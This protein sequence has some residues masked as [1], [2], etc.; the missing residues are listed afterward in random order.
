MI[1]SCGGGKKMQRYRI[2]EV[3]KMVDVPVETIRFLEQKGLVSPEKNTETGYRFYSVW[4]INLIL[5]YKKFRKIGFSSRETVD[6]VRDSS[7]ADL[8]EQL[9]AKRKEAA[10]LSHFY[11]A[12]TL[13]LKNF[14]SVL[15]NAPELVV[16]YY[17]MN[18]PENY[19]LF[20]RAHSGGNLKMTNARDTE[21]GFEEVTRN[22]PFVEHIYRLKKGELMLP[23]DQEEAEWG[24]T[25][26]KYWA[27][28][29]GIQLLPRMEHI[30]PVTAL[31]T[32]ITLD[33]KEYFTRSAAENALQYMED[34]HY[35]LCGDILGVYIA[36]V[37][38][39][40]RNVRYMELWMP[41]RGTDIPID[42]SEDQQR[43][44]LKKIFG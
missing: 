26:K 38:E 5:D 7:F 12:K 18:R 2:G 33:E 22:Y 20:T 31:F 4:D 39:G 36:T 13:K 43:R 35:T 23:E 42:F 44:E 24:F 19:S 37:R 11:Q 41:I 29:V 1:I 30:R 34:H 16:K 15:R 27:E 40:G 32:V 21:G 17:I 25:V 14:Q 9:D 28:R 6:L 10:Y 8:L 3:S